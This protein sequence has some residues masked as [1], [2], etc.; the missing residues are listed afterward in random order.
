MMAFAHHF[1]TVFAGPFG[2][3]GGG[4]FFAGFNASTSAA[5]LRSSMNFVT[6]VALLPRSLSK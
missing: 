6:R 5:V 1:F 4:I 3:G 2:V